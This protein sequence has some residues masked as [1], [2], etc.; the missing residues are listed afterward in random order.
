M[1]LLFHHVRKDLRH[2]CWSI[3]LTWLA[4]AGIFWLPAAQVEK[5]LEVMQW[6]P[7]IRYGS[8]VLLFL[9]V[10]RI[11][12]LDA[13]LRDTAFL[14]SRPV[15]SGTWLVS[16]L[17]AGV[18]ILLPIAL[19][20]VVVLPLAGLRLDFT[21]SLLIFFEEALVLS[22]VAALALALSTRME[23]YPRFITLTLGIAFTG[24]IAFVT[25]L[26]FDRWLTRGI[27]PEWGYDIEYLK[28]SRLLITQFIAVAGLVAGCRVCLHARHPER[29]GLV[30][31]GTALIAALAWFYWPVN[32]VK[33]FTRAEAEAP[34]AEWPD[35]SRLKFSFEERK[36]WSSQKAGPVPTRFTFSDGGYHYTKYRRI[37]AY[38]KLDGHPDEWFAY[39]N[40]FD[41]QLVLTNGKTLVSRDTAWAGL[42]ETAALPLVGIP[43]PWDKAS[44]MLNEVELAEFPL[45]EAADA[46]TGAKLKGK[47][48]I[49]IKRPVILAR[50][51]LRDGVS[52]RIGNRHIRITDVERIDAEIHYK[53]A[54]ETP[55]IGLRGGWYSEPHRRIEF[56]AVNVAKREHLTLGSNSGFGG[57]SGNYSLEGHDI[58]Q[59]IWHDSTKKWDGGV[60][61]GDWL[62]GAELL[63]VGDEYGGTLSQSFSFSDVTLSNP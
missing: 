31:S 50:L 11:V 23:T 43:L 22:V 14:R 9:T 42:S 24:F 10:G 6:L 26:V 63:V 44:N 19:F 40:S 47:I 30:I 62:D 2:S 28:L 32:F 5:R 17:A 39:R 27:K 59:T 55:R 56:L 1:N 21:D 60:I 45:P 25:Y 37:R 34:R 46:M 18:V 15:S 52:A 61:P 51:P 3:A 8:W 29:L 7:F 20:Q 38:T 49:P 36:Q 53:L 48:H 41:A 57:S 4:A 33:T 58:S 13:P 12:Q 54:I 35:L 16:K